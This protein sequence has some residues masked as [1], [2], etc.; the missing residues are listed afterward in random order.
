MLVAAGRLRGKFQPRDQSGLNQVIGNQKIMSR[1]RA[2]GWWWC[3]DWCD[4]Q[5]W[6]R[7]IFWSQLALPPMPCPCSL[8]L[9]AVWPHYQWR[10]CTMALLVRRAW[11]MKDN[12][13][14]AQGDWSQCLLWLSYFSLPDFFSLLLTSLPCSPS[15]PKP[16]T[17]MFCV[18]FA[19]VKVATVSLER[20]RLL[21]WTLSHL[22][23]CIIRSMKCPQLSYP[24]KWSAAST[25]LAPVK[26]RFWTFRGKTTSCK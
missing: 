19:C 16:N 1:G 13:F 25:Y 10:F 11:K 26:Q 17:P 21:W 6:Y 22:I 4:T 2:G 20:L 23:L 14:S 5:H 12:H 7:C 9:A 8:H 24:S 18:R 15:A 3:R